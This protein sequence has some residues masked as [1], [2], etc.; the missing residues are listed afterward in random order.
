MKCLGFKNS[1]VY[2]FGKGLEKTSLCIED[3]KIKEIGNAIQ[4]QALIELDEKYIVLPGFVDKHTHGAN[5]ADFMNPSKEQIKLIL[6]AV[7]KEGTT[8]CLATTMTQSIDNINL[9]LQTIASY[10]EEKPLGVEILG[11]HLEGPFISPK[12]AGAQPLKYII[13]CDI[14]TFEELNQKAKN[15]IKQVTLAVEENGVDL[16]KHLKD[17][18]VV[19]SLGHTDCTYEQAVEAVNQGATSISHM[20]NAMRGLHHRNAGTV[21]AGLFCDE[22]KCELI[23]DLIHVSKPVVQLLYKNKGKDGICL[24][25]DAM[26]AKWMP[27]GDYQLGGQKVIVKNGEAR[28][29]D[30]TL[31]GSTLKMNEAIH[32]FMQATGASL[33]DAV[34]LATINPARCLHVEDKK[35]SIEVGKDADFVVVDKDL[36][37]YMTICRGEIVYSKL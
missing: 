28:L 8:S 26:E 7:A 1:N 24:I 29:E 33:L 13:P 22:L 14:Q 25:T 18:G 15:H 23:C 17:K 35:G 2:V 12:H 37:V 32:N 20:F 3:G 30:G 31:A 36:N 34:D 9:S 21:G 11:V 19:A 27:D 4:N 16:V 6:S 5:S 10:I